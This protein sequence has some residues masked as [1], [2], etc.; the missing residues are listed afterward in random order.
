MLDGRSFVDGTNRNAG[1]NRSGR[2]DHAAVNSAAIRL[3]LNGT[4]VKKSENCQHQRYREKHLGC[5]HVVSSLS[6]GRFGCR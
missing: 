4:G 5:G 2:I 6:F 3:G 1:N